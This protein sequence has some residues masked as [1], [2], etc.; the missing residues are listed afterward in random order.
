ML[1]MLIG[2]QFVEVPARWRWFHFL[3]T[4]LLRHSELP[5]GIFAGGGD[6]S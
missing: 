4:D 3:T 6:N 1:A 5:Q 2:G